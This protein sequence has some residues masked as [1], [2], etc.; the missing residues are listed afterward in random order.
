MGQQVSL[1]LVE[2]EASATLARF[3][4]SL[5]LHVPSDECDPRHQRPRKI[6]CYQ[7]MI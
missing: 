6:C 4:S 3:S 1:L 5:N 7:F 2:I